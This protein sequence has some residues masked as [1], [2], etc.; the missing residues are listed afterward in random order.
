M[1]FRHKK[2][3]E[4]Q[5]QP[6]SKQIVQGYFKQLYLTNYIKIN[7]I[8]CIIIKILQEIPCILSVLILRYNRYHKFNGYN[9]FFSMGLI[10]YD[11]YIKINE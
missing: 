7:Y 3:F 10:L 6:H 1:Y 4:K 11:R 5:P 9:L 2:H 8:K